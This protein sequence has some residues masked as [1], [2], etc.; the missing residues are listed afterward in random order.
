[1]LL[2]SQL[3]LAFLVQWRSGLTVT[4]GTTSLLNLLMGKTS[5]LSPANQV[6]HVAA[7]G[8]GPY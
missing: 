7:F 4:S 5:H 1:M 2:P 6:K 8:A 3:H